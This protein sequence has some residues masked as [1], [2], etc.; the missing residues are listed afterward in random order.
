MKVFISWS[1]DTSRAIA[2]Q[3]QDWLGIVVQK[4]DFWISQRDISPG[5]RWALVLSNALEHCNI[6]IICVTQENKN[7]PWI[8][9]E[10]GAIARPVDGKVIPLLFDIT[11]SEL[12]GPLSQ[13]QSVSLDQSGMEKLVGILHEN[14]GTEL[15]INQR[16]KLFSVMWPTLREQVDN[17]VKSQQQGGIIEHSADVVDEIIEGSNNL[18]LTYENSRII[19]NFE[20]ENKRLQNELE[21][22]KLEDEKLTLRDAPLS[23]DQAIGITEDRLNILQVTIEKVLDQTFQQLTPSQASLL[24]SL[25]FDGKRILRSKDEYPLSAKNDLDVLEKYSLVQFDGNQLQIG[26]ELVAQYLEKKKN[27]LK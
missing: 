5:E 6:A 10:A 16:E 20:K 13:F 2:R 26:H 4:A 9:F 7:S 15:E 8:H 25:F 18:I 14:T 24:F 11:A 3:I 27:G 23:M 21:L 12:D 17:I 22:L 19:S 1:G